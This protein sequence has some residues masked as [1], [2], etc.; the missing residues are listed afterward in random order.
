[1]KTYF[2]S[3]AKKDTFIFLTDGYVSTADNLRFLN[4]LFID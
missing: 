3:T 4:S 2:E 1:M